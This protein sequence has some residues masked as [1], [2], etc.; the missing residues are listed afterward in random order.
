MAMGNAD[1]KPL[2]LGCASVAAR[3]VGR[4]PRLVDEDETLGIEIG[5]ALEP[6]FTPL[7]DIRAILLAG[8]RG[9]FS[10]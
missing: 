8:V 9:L 7:Q 3:H 5:L 10:T 4:G 6:V 1:A 2:A